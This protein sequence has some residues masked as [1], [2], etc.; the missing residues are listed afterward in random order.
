MLTL[1]RMVLEERGYYRLDDADR[2]LPAQY[3]NAVAHLP[4]CGRPER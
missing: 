1:R 2:P 3:A 4:G